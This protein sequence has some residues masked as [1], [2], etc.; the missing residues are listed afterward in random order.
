MG[1]GQSIWPAP[2]VG[3]IQSASP[4]HPKSMT[5]VALYSLTLLASGPVGNV[6]R[7]LFLPRS[8]DV[9]TLGK[10][11]GNND[12]EKMGNSTEMNQ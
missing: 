9:R 3:D 1:G 8:E 5:V 4:T 2:G 6:F 11:R 10:K 7:R 12:W